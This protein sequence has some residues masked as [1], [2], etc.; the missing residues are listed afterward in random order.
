LFPLPDGRVNLGAGL[1]NTFR[2]F[3]N[4]SAQRVFDAFVAMLPPAWE[5]TEDT[6]DGRVLSGPLP[7]G[8]NRMPQAVPGMLVVGDAAGIVN[9]FN[10]E[11]I[12]YAMESGELAAE[13]LYDALVRD[14][15][16]LAQLYPTLLRQR[17]GRYYTA[18]RGFVRAMGHPAAMRIMTDYGIPRPW[19]MR[20]SLRML[21]N[22]TDGPDGDGYD[23]VMDTLV[24]LMPAS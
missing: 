3:K 13:L 6:A 10:G 19:L 8:M 21:G 14:R 20:F 22:L 5:L 4:L 2:N 1:M 11:G 7:M 15:P 24:R 9:P 12:A 16:A 18:G 23:R 17:Y